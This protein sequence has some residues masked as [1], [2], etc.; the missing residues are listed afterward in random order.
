V[1]I[2]D[3]GLAKLRAAAPT[4]PLETLPTRAAETMP[5]TMLG[6]IGYMSP[7]QVRGESADHRATSLASVPSFMKC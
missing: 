4:G 7:E 3:F 6:T 2:L 1:K 5:G